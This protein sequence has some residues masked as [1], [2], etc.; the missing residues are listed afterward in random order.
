MSNKNRIYPIKLVLTNL[1]KKVFERTYNQLPL[2]DIDYPF[3]VYNIF[4]SENSPEMNL[5]LT[6]D[7]WSND[8]NEIEFQHKVD[9]LIS[10]LDYINYHDG[11]IHLSGQIDTVQDMETQ[12][13]ELVRI[14]IKGSY[15]IGKVE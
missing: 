3:A 9:E 10:E 2:S 7:L 12:E 11:S 4:I 5:T 6:V 13:E 1:I 14:Q 8:L 15:D